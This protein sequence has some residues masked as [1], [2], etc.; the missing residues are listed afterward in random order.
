MKR[1]AFRVDASAPMGT[2]HV[3]RCLSLAEVF[4]DR[5]ME[6]RFICR[7][8][9]G[10]LAQLL[11]GR[12]FPVATLPEPSAE[13]LSRSEGYAA[14]LG[15]PPEVDVS[16]TIEALAGHRADL[17]VVDHYGIDSSWEARLR[18]HAG[19]IL[20][21]D[22]LANRRHDCDVLLDQNYARSAEA[23]YAGLVPPSCMLLTGPRYALLA[24]DYST[25]RQARRPRATPSKRV[26]V[27]FGGS[28]PDNAT[29]LALRALSSEPLRHLE[30]D[31]VVGPNNPHRA[32]LERQAA[33]R[34]G[35]HLHGTQQ[36]LAAMMSCADLAI[37]AGGSTTWERM[38]L[39]LPSVVIAIAENQRPACEALA[40][41]RLIFYAGFLDDVDAGGL[42]SLISAALGD[43]AQLEIVAERGRECVDGLGAGRVAQAALPA[44]PREARLRPRQGISPNSISLVLEAAGTPLGELDAS[45][46][47]DVIELDWRTDPV[48]RDLEPYLVGRAMRLAYESDARGAAFCT[49]TGV[50]AAPKRLSIAVLSDAGSWMNEYI[51]TLL[52]GWLK[53]GHR[54][55]WVHD[56]KQLL[57][58]DFCFM[59]GSGQIAPPEVL[60]AYCKCLVV[61]ES[62]V[63]RG[64]G[65][66]PMTWQVLDGANR[67]PVTLLEAAEKVDSGTVFDQEWLS[68]DGTE[69]VDELRQ[70][71]AGA[72]L[73]LCAH[74]IED[75]PHSLARARPQSG[76]ASFYRR[77]TPA[78]SQLDVTR[79][80]ESQFNL[81]RVV[82]GERY[83]AFFEHRGCRYVLSIRKDA[84]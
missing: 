44:E 29:G 21:I 31:V 11:R 71:V 43:D 4:R 38:C 3:M 62:D 78:D 53:A 22:D 27:F 58:G 54:T 76:P 28:D 67:I 57:A 75:R 84:S 23:R 10:N 81:L 1:V 14:W 70:V 65:W 15:A 69:L 8:H 74:F 82:D 40:A 2:G 30:V 17:L 5:G 25:Y 60:S 34:P 72:T 73:R 64:K 49:R 52:L 45:R 63:P 9:G 41:S 20:A 7:A 47:A 18:P 19:T 42:E 36:H 66:S 56:R 55:L 68:L 50:Q 33:V 51:P 48:A 6:V 37:G 61:H 80:L 79:T 39:G 12:A 83:P 46:H 35:T 32:S 13:F 26:F 16:Q 77:R 24:R 59:L